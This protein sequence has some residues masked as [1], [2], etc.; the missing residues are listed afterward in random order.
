M[1]IIKKISSLIIVLALLFTL[2]SCGAGK[3]EDSSSVSESGVEPEI[4]LYEYTVEKGGAV[5][6]LCRL[7]ATHLEVPSELDGI[8]VTGIADGVF[9]GITNM[10]SA[11]IPEGITYIGKS[12]FEGCESLES[13]TLPSTLKAIGERAFKDTPWF[14]S[15]TDTFVVVG[16]GVGIK[17]SGSEQDVIVPENVNYL[18]DAFTLCDNVISVTVSEGV[19]AIGPRAFSGIKTLESVK[20]PSTV[21]SVGDSAFA[22]CLSLKEIEIPENVTELGEFLFSRCSALEKVTI[23]AKT[24]TLKMGTFANCTALKDVVLPETLT[25]MENAVFE[26]CPA[27]ASVNLPA[28]LTSISP[29]AF[30]D[31]TGVTATVES[32]SYAEGFCAERSIAVSTK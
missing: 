27:L 26:N 9:K 30:D 28:S 13:V 19:E 10:E 24:D 17:Y 31:G 16:D 11:V 18:S 8:P 23:N 22:F 12:A 14:A 4:K 1:N 15:L 21:R 25:S 3:T 6:T 32:G 7:L 29:G 2:A 5:I 20:I